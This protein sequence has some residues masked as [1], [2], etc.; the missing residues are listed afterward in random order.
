M[1]YH[2]LS[3]PSQGVDD[4]RVAKSPAAPFSRCRASTLRYLS[5]GRKVTGGLYL[6]IDCDPR[7]VA[8]TS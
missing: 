3:A 7:E 2:L 4:F 6:R 5:G 8:Q 1:K